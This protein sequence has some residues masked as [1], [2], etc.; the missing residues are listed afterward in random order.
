MAWHFSHSW[1]EAAHTIISPL[2]YER[3]QRKQKGGIFVLGNRVNFQEAPANIIGQ[4]M[5]HDY[6]YIQERLGKTGLRWS[7][8]AGEP[9][10]RV[11]GD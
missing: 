8:F 11:G 5:S 7:P 2:R 9:V 10:R 3:R 1:P 6:S 4:M